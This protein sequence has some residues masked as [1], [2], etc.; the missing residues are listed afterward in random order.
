MSKLGGMAQPL[1]WIATSAL[2]LDLLLLRSLIDGAI[3][4]AAC[5]ERARFELVLCAAPP[6]D[7][8]I[9]IT[10]GFAVVLSVVVGWSLNHPR[11]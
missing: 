9:P 5:L 8:A 4:S 2:A 7:A 10:A 3:A 1:V 11:A 6:P